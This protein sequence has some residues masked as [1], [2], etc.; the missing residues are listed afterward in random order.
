MPPWPG[1]ADAA[2]RAS[3]S[4]PLACLG[5][6]ALWGRASTYP[7]ASRPSTPRSSP[8]LSQSAGGGLVR[9]RFEELPPVPRSGRLRLGRSRCRHLGRTSRASTSLPLCFAR[10]FLL[11]LL[12]V[13]GRLRACGCAGA[14]FAVGRIKLTMPI[15]INL[16]CVSKISSDIS[17][18][19][20]PPQWSW[21]T[22]VM[23]LFASSSNC[24]QALWAEVCRLRRAED[25]FESQIDQD[26]LVRVTN[27][28]S[29]LVQVHA[30][31]RRRRSSCG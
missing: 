28:G 3:S 27:G 19:S 16:R 31:R 15:D 21:M 22:N 20:P 25:V 29:N 18:L 5:R 6:G 8:C 9:T 11:A 1:G 26:L 13:Q 24:L 30:G 4:S 14:G 10:C 17:M 2:G 12:R 23:I 7:R